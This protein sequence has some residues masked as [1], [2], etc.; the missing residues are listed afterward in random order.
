M[1]SENFWI[2]DISI[3]YKNYNFSKLVPSSDMTK[4]ENLNAITRL[5]IWIILILL[6]LDRTSNWIYIFVVIIFIIL[7]IYVYDKNK[8]LNN[9][10]Y[11]VEIGK[12]D[13]NGDVVYG[14]E[15]YH[16]NNG[17]SNDNNH[18]NITNSSNS[19]SSSNSISSINSI[20][21]R[22]STISSNNK[23]IDSPNVNMCRKPTRDN[24]FMNNNVEDIGK[25]SPLACNS[26]DEDIKSQINETF[27]DNLYKNMTD[28]FEI[29]NSERQF[30]TVPVPN[31]VP[32]TIKFA[33]WA[34]KSKRSCKTNEKDCSGYD[35]LKYR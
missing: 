25:Y 23:S 20:I 16:Y 24:P 6:V 31:G 7:A 12:F 26:D 3:L 2:N 22:N 4:Y 34:Y 1:K 5:C 28:L 30:Y 33:N 15:P 29:K 8:S 9:S 13:K 18:N 19:T 17:N 11:D 21:S 10:E 35:N 32:D 14:N 27:N